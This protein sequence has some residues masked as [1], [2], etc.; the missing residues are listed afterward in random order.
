[1]LKAF[2]APTREECTV[3]RAQ[4]NTA[5]A[6]LVLLNDPSFVEA[7]R[8][9]AARILQEGGR[10]TKDRL[11]Y[12]F[13]QAVSRDADAEEHDVLEKQLALDFRYYSEHRDAAEQLLKIGLTPAPRHLGKADLASWTLVA[14]VVLNLGEVI[15]RN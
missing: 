3:Q 8:A 9:F 1:M 6:A 14:R 5:P 7:D 15:T 11:N 10:T 2:D 13:R 12:A 4:S